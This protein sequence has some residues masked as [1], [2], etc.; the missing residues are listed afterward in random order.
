MSAVQ[1]L[2]LDFDRDDGGMIEVGATGQWEWGIPSTGPA[3]PGRVWATRLD[4]NYVNDATDA[5]EVDLP[6]LTAAVRP[7]LVLDHGY[8]VA[9]NDGATLWLWDGSVWSLA[10]PIGGYPSTY[11]FTARSDGFLTSAWAIP[12]DTDRARLVFH[13]DATG[14]APG[15]Y[16]RALSVW[17]GDVTAPLVTPIDT[18]Q[19]TTDPLGPYPIHLR[20]TDDVAVVSV[21]VEYAW[22]GVFMGSID[23]PADG[24]MFTANL[25]GAPLG[26]RVAWSVTASDG[27]QNARWPATGS[28]SFRVFL[29]APEHFGSPDPRLVGDHVHLTWDPPATDVPILGYRV[30]E[31]GGDEGTVDVESTA[32]DLP[33][34][35]PGSHTWVV[36]AH[37]AGGFGDASPRYTADV[38][39][40]GLAAVLP[41]S[42]WPGDHVR[43]NVTTRSA[44]LLD[45]VTTVS[46]ED[47]TVASVDVLDVDTVVV[48]I[49]VPQDATPGPRD[50]VVNGAFGETTFR[51]AFEVSDASGRPGVMTAPGGVEQGF[52][53]TVL[54]TASFAYAGD[55]HVDAGAD[56]VVSGSVVN[57]RVATVTMTVAGDAA[58][59]ART[60]VLDDGDRLWTAPIVV[61]E[62]PITPQRNCQT[63][64]GGS[65][66][67][68]L[69]AAMLGWRRSSRRARSR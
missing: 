23:A 25:P 56:I 41:P 7:T 34:S 17:D 66:L 11:G 26:T 28:E 10:A 20:V 45:P 57:D 59:G 6:D 24:S 22:D 14:S 15:W 50:L 51:D 1:L 58:P 67:V 55:V 47:V 46:I 12:S 19:D 65:A 18:P 8:D 39:V 69:V 2:D 5:L 3:T 13:A 52:S 48:E 64:P 4:A 27:A 31:I 54:F 35:T 29:P 53:G 40:P 33:V 42:A 16:L 63:A 36:A 68:A 49:N 30:D 61:T 43:L 62:R 32:A 38:E 44:Y 21:R 9:T 37:H 60:V